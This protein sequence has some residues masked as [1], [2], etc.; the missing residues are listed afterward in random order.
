M[1]VSAGSAL[2]YATMP[3]ILPRLKDIL[4]S[5][6]GTVTQ[7]IAIIC[8][9][10]RLLPKNHPCFSKEERH[11]YSLPRILADAASGVEFNW[12][13]IDKIIIFSLIVCGTVI[14]WLYIGAAV[15]FLITSSSFATGYTDVFITPLPAND[16][17]FMMLDKVF[18]LP[19]I[20]NSSVS[21]AA[22]FPA[23]FHR[24]LHALFQFYSWCVFFIALI[25]FLYHVIHIVLEITQDG[26]VSDHLSDDVMAPGA[27]SPSKGFSWL[28][29]RF[30][31]AFGLLIPFGYGFNSGQWI[32]LY[33]AKFGSGMATNAWISYNKITG[34]NPTG[35][36]NVRLIAKPP[37]FD[38]SGL[39]KALFLLN[40]CR[41]ITLLTQFNPEADQ[42]Y[43]YI[44]NG[45]KSKS[46][47][48]YPNEPGFMDKPTLS[49]PSTY[50]ASLP[51]IAAGDVSDHFVQILKYSGY[52]DIKMVIGT[53][54]PADPEKYK[55][56]PGKVLPTCGEITIPVTSLTGEGLFAAEGYLYAVMQTMFEAYRPGAVVTASDPIEDMWL[57]L[58]REYLRNSGS[59]KNAKN[60]LG[61]SDAD[62]QSS[63]GGDITLMGP[64]TGPVY[65][66]YWNF[67]MDKYFRY[68]FR[69]PAFT[70]YDFLADTDTAYSDP[71][72]DASLGKIYV[73]RTSAAFS[74]VGKTN[75]LLMDVG[76][77]GYGWGGAGLWYN[78]I[79]ESNGSLYTAASAV[80]IITKFPMVMQEIK[81]Q[82]EKT[83]TQ[84]TG[85]YCE[86]FNPRKSGASSI[87]L[88]NERNQFVVEQ[89]TA[90]YAF[91]EQL[92][93]NQ[94]L[95]QDGVTRAT[96]S[97]N[98]FEKAIHMFFSEFQ[99]FN[100]VDNKEVTPMAQLT[101][102]GRI[103]IDKAI[104]GITASAV[105]YAAGGA[106]H[107]TA[108]ENAQ[109]QAFASSL[110]AI[111][112]AAMAIALIGLSSGFVL[113]YMLPI[114][115]FI[116]F[117]FAVGRWVK[118]IF[119]ALV[120]VP[121]W[122]LA[123]MR[124]GG[125]GLPGEAAI[126]GY[127]FLL[128]IFI[129]P[130]L[131]V[132]SLVAAFAIFSAMTIGLNTVFTIMSANLFGSVA[133]SLS[134]TLSAGEQVSYIALARGMIDQFFLSV[135]YIFLVYTIGIGCFKLIDL[136]P[137]NIMRWSGYGVQSF[138]ASDVSD[139]MVEQWQYE[140]PQRFNIATRDMG[141]KL[142][143]GLYETGEK[144]GAEKRAQLKADRE[145]A[146]AEEKAK[147]D[148]EAK[149]KGAGK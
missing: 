14:M 32:T 90:L 96:P 41:R 144:L 24:A 65:S 99:I 82:R 74:A 145:K 81:D 30:V 80:P 59:V 73:H 86:K 97:T 6:F 133:P 126:G 37:T 15:I 113:Y 88:L 149:A 92:F 40:S 56:Y 110:G 38:N 46:L 106:A 2:N 137:D 135:F 102:V 104:I 87:N 11:K 148:A 117:F 45:S 62:F 78:K 12:K 57:A 138:G 112:D 5:G 34:N 84:V 28:P 125:P 16:V 53:F 128:E 72:V 75:P 143:D 129:R 101:S 115:P 48:T 109:A 140:L 70:A 17:A 55:E 141:E 100:N 51:K 42:A 68:A 3:G 1:R 21:L 116:Y 108:G 105:S 93:E 134:S 98:P 85:G 91:C 83:D 18:G 95:N 123:H 89:A 119:E 122:A 147:A 127:F 131:T 35:S 49:N 64:I 79:G 136:I 61:M 52:H 27:D 29:I 107:I 23:P 22:P 10:A 7:L 130:I 121:L 39:I 9:M 67:M 69:I 120:G 132:F 44:V 25:I 4:F 139:D 60:A 111:G 47:F 19:G 33:V 146:Q 66:S 43:P 118:V 31:V 77:L 8:Y 63:Y 71:T 50:N 20:F 54:D 103:L 26:K 36:E 124:V 142:R 114:M 58:M 94:A 76:I 13:N